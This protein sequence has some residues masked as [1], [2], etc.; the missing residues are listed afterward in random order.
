ML[1][2][3]RE[4]REGKEEEYPL[5]ESEIGYKILKVS[6]ISWKS[7]AGPLDLAC[8]KRLPVSYPYILPKG[9]SLTL[10]REGS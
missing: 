2:V 9:Q 8:L 3:E 1:S 4:E 5:R 7:V 6:F 10:L